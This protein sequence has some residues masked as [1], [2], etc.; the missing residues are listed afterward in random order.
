MKNEKWTDIISTFLVP[1]LLALLGL[2]L[3]IDPNWATALVSKIL[4]WALIAGGVICAIVTITGWPVNRITRV[5]VTVLLLGVGI[6]LSKNPLA[7]A[8][9]IGKIIG[10]FLVIQGGSGLLDARG[11][12]AMSGITLAAGIF[13]LLFPLTLSKLV[14]RICG[15]V[16]LVLS[17]SNILARLRAGK[18]LRASDDPNIIDAEP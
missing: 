10:I 12:K 4:G 7:L 5:V 3:L 17:V 15:A 18:A 11:A 14:F 1:G 9:N 16:L 6:Y 2:S 8:A 13:L